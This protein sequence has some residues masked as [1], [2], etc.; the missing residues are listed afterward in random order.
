MSNI[1]NIL[2]HS[3]DTISADLAQ[4]LTETPIPSNVSYDQFLTQID[5]DG[6]GGG[7]FFE[8]VVF[9]SAVNWCA[10]G[11]TIAWISTIGMT[12]GVCSIIGESEGQTIEF[13]GGIVI[14]GERWDT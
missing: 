1:T 5:M 3:Y 9:G 4:A 12:D 11:E 7:K 2:V 10:F 13:H 14:L 8:S 6:A